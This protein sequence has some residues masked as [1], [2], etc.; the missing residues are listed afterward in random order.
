M[1]EIGRRVFLYS[2]S[3]VCFQGLLFLMYEPNLDSML[4]DQIAEETFDEDVGLAMKGK[5][6]EDDDDVDEVLGLF[7]KD[8]TEHVRI[9]YDKLATNKN[10][11]GGA[12]AA[13]AAI[14]AADVLYNHITKVLDK[15][16]MNIELKPVDIPHS[17]MI[18][19]NF[20]SRQQNKLS[21]SSSIHGLLFHPDF[22]TLATQP[23]PQ[24]DSQPRARHI[25][26]R[27]VT[28][29]SEEHMAHSEPFELSAH[30]DEFQS[31]RKYR[32]TDELHTVSMSDSNLI[33]GTDQLKAV[34][35]AN[36]APME[37]S[38]S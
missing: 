22:G 27:S 7:K 3:F 2:S 5:L 12:T 4:N 34:S 18:P 28:F 36:V 10:I 32:R 38:V 1:F 30:M 19:S 20:H 23:P 35:L 9:Y 17:S 11:E 37:I 33:D 31:L 8:N 25:L 15:E 14:P 6:E 29:W 13:E 26:K 21:R 24:M 16:R